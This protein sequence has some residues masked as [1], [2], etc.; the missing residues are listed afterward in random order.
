MRRGT[1]LERQ[2]V[3][4]TTKNSKKEKEDKTSFPLPAQ[5]AHFSSNAPSARIQA[6]EAQSSCTSLSS[7]SSSWSPL[8]FLTTAGEA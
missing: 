8:L 3:R 6:W 1:F 7:L 4:G 2:K 5:R